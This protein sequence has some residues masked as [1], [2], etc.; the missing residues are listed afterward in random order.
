[1]DNKTINRKVAMALGLE[2][3]EERTEMFESL[4]GSFNENDDSI[5][6]VIDGNIEFFNPCG[7]W[8]DAGPIIVDNKI[9]LTPWGVDGEHWMA[10]DKL[11]WNEMSEINCFSVDSNPPRAAMICFLKMKDAENA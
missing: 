6:V 10:T 4:L 2:I 3:S 7:N 5:A 8:G 9:T 1:M 11:H